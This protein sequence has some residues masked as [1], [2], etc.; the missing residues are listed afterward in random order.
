MIAAGFGTT[1]ELQER[2][3]NASHVGSTVLGRGE[4]IDSRLELTQYALHDTDIRFLLDAG[5]HEI[6]E[7][8]SADLGVA[9]HIPSRTPDECTCQR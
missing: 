1:R 8:A 3:G 9:S 2:C 4:L 6:E 5:D 7:V